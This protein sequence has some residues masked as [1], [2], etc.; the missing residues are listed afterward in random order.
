MHTRTH[1]TAYAN[2]WV[3][4][5]AHF[6][7][8]GAMDT[9]CS[10]GFQH[11]GDQLHYPAPGPRSCRRNQRNEVEKKTR[12]EWVKDLDYAKQRGEKDNMTTSDTDCDVCI[13]TA[14]DTRAR[15]SLLQVS[16]VTDA[17]PHAK[18]WQLPACLSGHRPLISALSLI[19]R[20]LPS[21]NQ[22]E[23]NSGY[24][25]PLPSPHFPGNRAFSWVDP[26]CLD[27]GNPLI[28]QGI[29]RPLRW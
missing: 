12:N 2:P 28:F 6:V 27:L 10:T 29:I 8:S 16:F 23:R 15:G 1:H 20:I 7:Q 19:L 14:P 22:P 25:Y 11:R 4:A 5:T 17:S 24:L 3:W 26:T 9:F 18:L 21:R 13:W